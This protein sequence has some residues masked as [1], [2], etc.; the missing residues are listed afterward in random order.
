MCRRR[1]PP[2]FTHEKPPRRT[3]ELRLHLL[4]PLA[5]PERILSVGT[6]AQRLRRPSTLTRTLFPTAN[7]PP[8]SNITASLYTSRGP[9]NSARMSFN[10][11]AHLC[12]LLLPAPWSRTHEYCH[13][14]CAGFQACA[15][16]FLLF[17]SLRLSYAPAFPPCPLSRP[18]EPNDAAAVPPRACVS[19][20]HCS[21]CHSA[22]LAQNARGEHILRHLSLPPEAQRHVPGPT[23]SPP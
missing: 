9:W 6:L 16:A 17:T 21:V 1:P 23:S 4:S 22:C 18:P 11:R 15:G 2:R 12:T 19:Y 20:R 13:G 7:S 10:A 5:P 14:T 8:E 3:H